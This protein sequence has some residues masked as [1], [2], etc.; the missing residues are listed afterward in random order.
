MLQDEKQDTPD[1]FDQVMPKSLENSTFTLS[2]ATTFCPDPSANALFQ[3]V[4]PKTG[5]EVHCLLALSWGMMKRRDN[6]KVD[7]IPQKVL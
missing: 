2:Y 7:I 1:E 5:T 6:K 3:A 4:E